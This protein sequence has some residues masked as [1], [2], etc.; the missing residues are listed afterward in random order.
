MEDKK[1]TKKCPNCGKDMWFK[2]PYYLKKS[3]EKNVWCRQC[4]FIQRSN[5]PIWKEKN[6]LIL[7]KRNAGY[8]GKNNP[9]F[10]KTHDRETIKKMVEKRDTSTYT[11]KEFREKMSNMTS[12][13]NNGMY[14][15]TFYKQ[16]V[17]KYGIDIAN[18]KLKEFKIKQSILNSG[19][20]NSMYGKPSP[21]GSGQGWK[22]H[23]KGWFFRSLRE[24][25][26]MINVIEKNNFTWKNGEVIKIEYID[27]LGHKRTYRPDFIINEIIVVEIKPLRLHNTPLIKCKSSAAEDYCKQNNL[28]FEIIDPTILTSNE[29]KIL[30]NSNQIIFTDRYK[31][32]YQELYCK[33]P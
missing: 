33:T 10:G 8:K 17:E 15:K 26:Y 2:Y 12:G 1:Y 21:K 20:N 16:W 13:K 27:P 7:E 22:G 25:S 23:Y 9:F 30:V 31:K 4:S 6:R 19:E 3:I 14:G 18:E 29:I 11:T 32:R 28:K 24:L 5:N